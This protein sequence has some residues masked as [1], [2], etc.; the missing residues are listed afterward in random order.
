MRYKNFICFT[1][2]LI[3]PGVAAQKQPVFDV[4]LLTPERQARM[5]DGMGVPQAIHPTNALSAAGRASVRQ[6]MSRVKNQGYRGTCSVFATLALLEA[7]AG[8]SLSE[9]CFANLMGQGESKP[10]LQRIQWAHGT[11]LLLES[12]CPYD[13]VN[14]SMMPAS[15]DH[16]K[17]APWGHA[18]T[19]TTASG[20]DPV[21]YI[22]GWINK[23]VPVSASYVA[24]GYWWKEPA[25]LPLNVETDEQQVLRG[26]NG[27]RFVVKK[28]LPVSVWDLH[29]D[30][31]LREALRKKWFEPNWWVD[32]IGTYW[33]DGVERRRSFEEFLEAAGPLQ[34]PSRPEIVESCKPDQAAA[35]E[36]FAL[37][38]SS[39][40]TVFTG[41]DDASQSLEFKN[42]W[43]PDW[44]HGGYGYMSYEYLRRFNTNEHRE[45]PMVAYDNRR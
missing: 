3:A 21:A 36:A 29:R 31:E 14:G 5:F 4:E 27:L 39:H 38:C 1:L 37:G 13:G 43:G 10:V 6:V 22:K 45:S 20:R 8:I 44:R 2:L 30:A 9:Q 11:T 16:Y 40:V 24:T 25:M 28:S 41:Y 26:R 7:N 17:I 35:S 34:V 42:S 18:E 23:G 19:M 15:L 32:G 12:D 33:R